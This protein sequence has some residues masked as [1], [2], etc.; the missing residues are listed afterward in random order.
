MVL[1]RS[2]GFDSSRDRKT[3]ELSSERHKRPQLNASCISVPDTTRPAC[4][5]DD[6]KTPNDHKDEIQFQPRRQYGGYQDH[7]L[8]T[9]LPIA[10]ETT[11]YFGIQNILAQKDFQLARRRKLPIICRPIQFSCSSSLQHLSAWAWLSKFI[12]HFTAR[13]FICKLLVSVPFQL[14]RKLL[15]P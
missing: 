6:F 12:T 3:A 5:C 2:R 4:S 8:K 9:L 13:I 1:C 10:D 11:I 7:V 15:E 14:I